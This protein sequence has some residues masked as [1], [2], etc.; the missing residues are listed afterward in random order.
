MK[1][2]L[3]GLLIILSVSMAAQDFSE[4]RGPNRTGV[5]NETGLLQKWPE[6]GPELI[7]SVENLYKGYSSVSVANNTIYLTGINDTVDVL[8]AVELK[9]NI[10][11]QTPYGRARI[12]AYPESRCTP[13]VENDRVYV[14]SGSGDVACL[15]ALTGEIIW[16]VKA[17]EKFEGTIGR[18]GLAESLLII[19]NKVIYTP[20]GKKTT[21]V[22]LD[23]TT[24]ETI[25]MSESID[26]NP[27]YSSP[28]LIEKDDKKLIISVTPNSIIGVSP[29][30]GEIVWNFDNRSYS[31]GRRKNQTNTPLYHD[32][33]IYVTNGYN[34]K[35][36]MLDLSEN[37]KSVSL[38]WVDTVLDVHHGGVVYVD[39]YIYG[40]NWINNGQGKWC[41]IEWESGKK[42]Y[43]TEWK[44]KG[45]II[46][47]DGML[48][49][50]EEK[51]GY[52]ALVE[53]TPDGFDVISSFNIN[54]GTGPHWSHPVIK[55]GILY[56]RHMDALMAYSISSN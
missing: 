18:W 39:G 31:G 49:C 54:L 12:G 23:K 37:F 21:M 6:N 20:G 15:N 1:Q 5:Y 36:V 3:T 40:A 43:E 22:A 14:S 19:D 11:W 56:I 55:N 27:S 13:T 53:A 46:Y 45:S 50:Y 2:I 29:A 51:T 16:T 28:L 33:R 48:Y 26:D 34:H 47:A 44:T 8:I 30:N 41:C 35:S 24:G 38:A 4:W 7:W 9:G 25:W 52:I 17:S 32:G 10:K 42:Q